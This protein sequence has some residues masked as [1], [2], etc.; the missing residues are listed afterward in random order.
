MA[1]L[2]ESISRPQSGKKL[3]KSGGENVFP[4]EKDYSSTA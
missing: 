1:A 2:L 4:A 3:V